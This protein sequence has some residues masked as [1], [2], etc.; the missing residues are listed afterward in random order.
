MSGNLNNMSAILLSSGFIIG[1]LITWLAM[2][3]GFTLRLETTRLALNNEITMLKQEITKNEDELKN[4][5]TEIEKL[6]HLIADLT[7]EN[8][9]LQ[10]KLAVAE[11]QIKELTKTAGQLRKTAEDLGKTKDLMAEQQAKI[12]ELKTRL[13]EERHSNAEK[14]QLIETAKEKLSDRFKTLAQEIL[15]EKGKIFA[16][17][18]ET[19]LNTMLNPLREQLREFQSRVNEVHESQTRDQ[20][21]LRQTLESLQKS[22]KI[23]NQEAV[24]L[25]RALKG[26]NKIQGNWGEMLLEKVLE[27]S[28]LRKG[29]EYEVQ[30]AIRDN[31]NKLLRPDV[32]VRLPEGREVVIDAKVSLVAYEKFCSA[33][34]EEEKNA[35]L[36]AHIQAVR[37]HVR[38]LSRKNYADLPGL[39]TPDFVLMFLAIEPAFMVAMQKDEKMF[40]SAFSQRIIIVTPTTLLATLRTIENI[41]RFERQNQNTRVIAEMAGKVYD[42]LRGFIEDMNKVDKQLATTRTTFDKAM[43]KLVN[44]RGNLINQA[45]KFVELGVKVKKEIARPVTEFQGQ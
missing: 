10:K 16:A 3:H 37:N 17:S 43:G 41:W 23:L 4:G 19:K 29:Y 24:N 42:K 28:G 13:E 1:G 38:L 36:T 45:E 40:S 8:H 6:Q 22:N 39:K 35:A 7:T 33:E 5:W 25:T 32:I 27:Q 30:N 2:R 9:E 15:E 20:A 34:N 11:Q 26:D 21:S 44:G 12:A 18:N 14:I 31:E